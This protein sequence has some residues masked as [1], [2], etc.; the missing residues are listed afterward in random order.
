[1]LIPLN[2]AGEFGCHVTRAWPPDTP[3]KTPGRMCAGRRCAAWVV[4]WSPRQVT[5]FDSLTTRP[6]RYRAAVEIGACGL[7]PRSLGDSETDVPAL[8]L[9]ARLAELTEAGV[10]TFEPSPPK[11]RGT[12]LSRPGNAI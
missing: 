8:E 2:R 10:L 4:L 1:M 9:R 3:E 5:F 6:G 12:V 11:Q 7:L